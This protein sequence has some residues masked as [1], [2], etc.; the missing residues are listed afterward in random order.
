MVALTKKENPINLNNENI[1]K[2]SLILSNLKPNLIT[3]TPA[4]IQHQA[5]LNSESIVAYNKSKFKTIKIFVA[6]NK[7]GMN[8][9]Y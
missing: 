6:S 5:S 9:Y 3:G 8:F 7:N 4:Q 1:E 2:L